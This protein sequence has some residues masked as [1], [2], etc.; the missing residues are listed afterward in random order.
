MIYSWPERVTNHTGTEIRSRLLRKAAVRNFGQMGESLIQQYR[1][2]VCP[3]REPSSLCRSVAHCEP[4]PS[5]GH[6]DEQKPDRLQRLHRHRLGQVHTQG[7]SVSRSPENLDS[8]D[9]QLGV[10]VG[11]KK[12]KLLGSSS[13]GRCLHR[14]RMRTV[15]STTWVMP[16]N[17]R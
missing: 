2:G 13:T 4:L 10:A 1:V 7:W 3:H 8:V 14:M 5:L 17:G 6:R 16:E 12:Q 9:L 11:C 15:R